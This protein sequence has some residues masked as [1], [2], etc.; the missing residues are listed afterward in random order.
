HVS[1]RPSDARSCARLSRVASITLPAGVGGVCEAALRQPDPRAALPRAVHAPRRP[2]QSP[3]RRRH[4]RDGLVWVEGL[5]TR[6]PAAHADARC[7]RIPPALPPARPTET[8]RR[9]SLLR[10]ARAPVPHP[11]SCD[12]SYGLG[13]RP[14]T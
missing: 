13:G 2:L 3:A 12:V 7:R 6:E 10:P 9:N 8:L 11:R 14:A 1:R 4:G 5:S